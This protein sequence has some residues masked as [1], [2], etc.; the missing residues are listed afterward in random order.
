MSIKYRH[1]RINKITSVWKLKKVHP[2]IT[3]Y[4]IPSSTFEIFKNNIKL[5]ISKALH[6]KFNEND[7]IFIKNID[8]GRRN[9]TNVTPNGAVVPKREFHLEYN[10]VLRSWCQLVKEII[11]NN[12]KLLKLFRITPNIRI[13][14]G[15]ELLDNK[16][17]GLSTSYP[18]SDAWVEGPWGMN[19]FIP[20]FGDINNNNM[21]YLQL[22]FRLK[23]KF[24]D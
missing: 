22:M 16:I 12:P 2:L 18:H 20:F 8:K 13:K 19:C 23:N 5:Y 17:R 11:S 4:N 15:K 6:I 14:F 10:L 3:S 7:K 21:I 1:Q 9:R 24:G